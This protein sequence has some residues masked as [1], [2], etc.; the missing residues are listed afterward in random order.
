MRNTYFIL[1]SVVL[2]MT[3]GCST[4][5]KT[6][7]AD[8]FILVDDNGKKRASL[9]MTDKGPQLAM[10]GSDE[11]LLV[12]L[13]A[14]DDSSHLVFHSRVNGMTPLAPVFIG[15]ANRGDEETGFIQLVAYDR[16]ELINS[17]QAQ[18]NF[19]FILDP[20]ESVKGIRF[21]SKDVKGKISFDVTDQGLELQLKND[22]DEIIWKTDPSVANK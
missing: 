1:L 9:S 18:D 17:I 6:I 5:K 22:E 7:T 15:V 8:K 12:R 20:Q 4:S 10:F 11:N 14:L 16:N 21:D 19:Y 3:V 13:E 2:C